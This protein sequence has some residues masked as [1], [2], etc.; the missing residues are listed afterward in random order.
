MR[1]LYKYCTKVHY[2]A[3]IS[4]ISIVRYNII[5]PLSGGKLNKKLNYFFSKAIFKFIINV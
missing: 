3:N 2:Q 4:N 5:I 1:M